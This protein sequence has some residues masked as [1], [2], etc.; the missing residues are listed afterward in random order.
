MQ[1]RMIYN[2]VA[3][4]RDAEAD[5]LKA[6]EYLR[7]SGW[8]VEL[9]RTQQAGDVKRL[10]REARDEG[11]QLV[12]AVGGDGTIG[13]V[14]DGLAN[15]PTRMGVIPVGTG[16]LW[17]HML[18]IPVWSTS[19]RGAIGEA[20]RVLVDGETR[21]VDLGWA[22]GR[23]FLLWAGLGFDARVASEIEPHREV[24]RSLGNLAYLV[25]GLAQSLVMRGERTTVIVDGRV[26]RQRL[27]MMVVSNVQLYGPRWELAPQAQLDDG[28]LDVYLFKGI[29]TVDTFSHLFT[30]MAGKQGADPQIEYYQ[31]RHVSVLADHPLPLHLDGDPA[32]FTPVNIQVMPRALKVVVPRWTPNTLFQDGGFEPREEPT[33]VGRISERLRQLT[34]RWQEERNRLQQQLDALRGVDMSSEA[35]TSKRSTG[36]GEDV[37]TGS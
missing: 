36:S 7:S 10:A 28:L 34:D 35:A 22:D 5:V 2:P 26:Y 24:R 33:L 31:A 14:A 9:C 3:G 29:N 15:S 18:G 30:L 8:D 6:Q 12:V 21:P 13:Q 11:T 17:A 23:C 37:S 32:G 4:H 19:N 20:A 16:N 1:V 27:I 25:A